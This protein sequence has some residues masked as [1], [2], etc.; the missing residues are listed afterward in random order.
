MRGKWRCGDDP[1]SPKRVR[2]NGRARKTS[3]EKYDDSMMGA[4]VVYVML[5]MMDTKAVMVMQLIE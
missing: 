2:G 3:E 1:L 4:L 5:A